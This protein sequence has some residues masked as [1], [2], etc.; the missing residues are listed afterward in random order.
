M[1]RGIR[2]ASANWLGRTVL[3]VLLGL[4]AVSFTIWGIGDIFRGFGRS[5]LARIGSTEISAEQFRQLYSE[6]LQQLGR[7]LGRPITLDQARSMGLDQQLVGELIGEATLDERVK[8]LRLGITDAE[9]A[10]RITT[11]PDL[12]SP[13]GQ[14]DRMRF[15]ML[16]RNNQITEQRFIAE[17]RRLLLRRQLAGTVLSGTQLPKAAM[18]AAERYQNEQRAVEYV[19]LERA[20]AGEIPDPTPE[21]LAKYFE[22]RKVLFRAPEYRKIVVLPLLPGEQAMWTEISDADVQ[23]AYEER[24]ARYLTPERRT[25]QQIVFDN[26][27]AAQAAADR[28][29]KGESF[30]D[31]AKERKLGEKEIDLGTLAKAAM[32]DQAVANAAFALKDNEVSAPIKGRFGTVLVRVLKIEPEQVRPLSEVGD[33][34]RR[35]LANERARAE[36]LPL[37]D[38]IED[39]RSIGRTLSE[40][41]ANLKLAARTIEV[42]REGISPSGAPTTGL[43]DAQRLLTSAFA[44]EAGVENDPLQVAGGYVWYEVTGIT[45]ERE[46]TLDEVREQVE[47]RWRN[48]QVA[49][50]LRAKAA[51]MLDKL[52][53]GTPFAEVAAAAGLKIET[54]AEVKRGNALPPLSIRTI[55][56]IFRTAKDAYGTAEAAPPGEQVAFRVTDIAMP[57]VD[58]K[59]EEATRIRDNLNRS[60]TEDVFGGYLGSLQRQVGV[61][62]NDNALKQVVTGQN[63]NTTN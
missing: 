29:A 50:V 26:P 43:P 62:I 31:I 40:A 25:L 41:A 3:G 8:A 61:T 63:P 21:A 14:F 46:R 1:L 23:R 6:R 4:I 36:I 24:R 52:K 15:E 48:D 13:S 49:N 5:G 30:L 22:E 9:M 34:L 45:P 32:V 19:L 54:K 60:F 20:Q 58:E 37:Y 51:E 28:I 7:Q 39:E 59:S 44:T 16:L 38:K 55:D 57:K 35:D 42:N 10:R 18:E 17:Q 27:Q 56:A 47:T 12:L 33:E 2:T 11:N 53:G